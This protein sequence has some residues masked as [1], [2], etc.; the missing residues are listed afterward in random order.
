MKKNL[1]QKQQKKHFEF[2]KKKKKKKKK[3]TRKNG[4][5]KLH[6]ILQIAIEL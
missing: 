4:H 6:T 1:G 5:P 2:K 3:K